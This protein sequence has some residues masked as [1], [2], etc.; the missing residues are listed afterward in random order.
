MNLNTNMSCFCLRDGMVRTCGFLDQIIVSYCT[1]YTIYSK[2]QI[3]EYYHAIIENF[4]H[5]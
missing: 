3:L 5:L 1:L 4:D 2:R